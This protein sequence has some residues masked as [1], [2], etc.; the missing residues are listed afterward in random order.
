M[1]D[2][3]PVPEN[4]PV[5]QIETNTRVR[6]G[7]GGPANLQAQ[8]LLNRISLLSSEI[9]DFSSPG[10]S[11]NIGFK[12]AGLGAV[13]RNVQDKL[14]EIVSADDFDTL[15]EAV[16]TGFAVFANKG[17]ISISSSINA[18]I[19]GTRIY[20]SGIT[21]TRIIQTSLDQ[22]IFNVSADDVSICGISLD[23]DG[24]PSYGATA[25]HCEGANAE[26][27]SFKINRCHKGVEFDGAIIGL[28]HHFKI[29]NYS[30]SALSFIDSADIN[31]DS[32]LIDAL[33]PENG[34]EGGISIRNFGEAL[35]FSNGDILNGSYSII[36]DAQTTTQ[37]QVPAHNSFSNVY[38]DGSANGS[39]FAKLFVTEFVNCWWSAGRSG[40]GNPGMNLGN[41]IALGFTNCRFAG[42][43]SHGAMVS[44]QADGVTFMNSMFLGNSQTA[45][46]NVASGL[47]IA[48][49]SKNIMVI[50]CMSKN[51]YFAGLQKYGIE[52]GNGCTN[53]I[54]TD[55]NVT[56]N[57]T[58]GIF[59]G[60]GLF[61]CKIQDNVGYNPVGGS[62]IPVG[63]SPFNYTAGP[64][65][66][67]IYVSGGAV[68][69]I[70]QQGAAIFSST[71]KTIHLGPNESMQV[72]Y[73]SA[74]FMN[75]MV[76]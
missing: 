67:T 65:P 23:Y 49:G 12:Q 3:I 40:S 48:P 72:T 50:G 20:G 59:K 36:T 11:A 73:S 53:I 25:I 55:N 6:G 32:F 58:A 75:R 56:G 39:L 74:P 5:P 46:D 1:T 24:T 27:H 76:H 14:R 13:D 35:N 18:T 69:Q 7:P 10:G 9:D 68:S 30:S 19:S 45:G 43:G 54:V 16:D 70:I 64:S 63:G 26:F 61:G 17:D 33:I 52:I 66:E 15:Q 51:T 41:A 37:G 71:D 21:A 44:D 8:A 38:F 60:A 47:Y 29:Y 2:L 31:T 22:R 57:A 34:A 4:T 62:A 28:L 42:C